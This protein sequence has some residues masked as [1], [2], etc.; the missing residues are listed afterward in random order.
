[1]LGTETR[2]VPNPSRFTD[3]PSFRKTGSIFIRLERTLCIPRVDCITENRGRQWVLP[4][5]QDKR[6]ESL[7]GS[8]EENQPL[9]WPYIFS[10]RLY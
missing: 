5:Q 1:L 3:C 9:N 8:S 4:G 2:N 10:M 6:I 7:G